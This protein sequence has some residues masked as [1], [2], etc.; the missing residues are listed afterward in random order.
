MAFTGVAALVSAGAA[1]T[2]VTATMVLAAVAEV[3]LAMTVV[4]AV[5]GSKSLMKIG[6]AMSLVGGIG[7][8]IAGAASGAGA[9]GAASA[10]GL[11]EAATNA[12]ASTAANETAGLVGSEMGGMAMEGAAAAAPSAGMDLAAAVGDQS[13]FGTALQ[14]TAAAP[15]A[16][17]PTAEMSAALK[18]TVN[19]IVTPTGPAGAQAPVTPAD[20]SVGGRF[21]PDNMDL[22]GGWNPATANAPEASG[23]YFSKLSGWADKNKQ[24]F[25]AGMQMVGGAMKGA[26]ER[27]MW[28][29]KMGLERDRFNR[30][31]SVAKF[32]PLQPRGIVQ[33]AGA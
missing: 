26:N 23:S 4:G 17:T 24:L 9:A 11:S 32:Q 7:G 21:G 12:A 6:G 18:P 13:I 8:M 5:T 19:D 27:G 16:V 2:A 33:G 25:S 30:A 29:E 14:P 31:N 3:G 15:T 1:G 28:N 20:Y 22:G 10:T